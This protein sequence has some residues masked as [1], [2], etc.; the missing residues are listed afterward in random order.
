MGPALLVDV[1]IDGVTVS[2][3]V[4]SDAQSTIIS[5]TILYHIGQQCTREGKPVPILE[6]PT[7]KLYGKDGLLVV[8]SCLSLHNKIDGEYVRAPVY[9]FSLVVLKHACWE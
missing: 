6:E 7:A 4:D 5:R 1:S 2:A 3:M 9:L 8:S